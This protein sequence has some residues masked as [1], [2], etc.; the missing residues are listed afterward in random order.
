MSPHNKTFDS[1]VIPLARQTDFGGEIFDLVDGIE[2]NRDCLDEAP[3][4]G[5]CVHL[6]LREGLELF[7]RFVQA[8]QV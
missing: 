2:G 4:F 6:F 3:V 7:C 8:M 1:L 5:E